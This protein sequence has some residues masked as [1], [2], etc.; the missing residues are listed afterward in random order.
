M[1]VAIPNINRYSVASYAGN[2]YCNSNTDRDQ[3][4]LSPSYLLSQTGQWSL[5][6][7]LEYRLAENLEMIQSEWKLSCIRA[8]KITK[9]YIVLL[10][11][12][13]LAS[14]RWDKDNMSFPSLFHS[15]DYRVTCVHP[16]Q[17]ICIYHGLWLKW[18]LVSQVSNIFTYH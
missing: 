12:S 13:Y 1:K 5:R 8:Y 7:R 6:R 17:V 11:Y 15:F 14:Y 9:M 3:F 18:Q 10:K 2:F 16:C 4:N